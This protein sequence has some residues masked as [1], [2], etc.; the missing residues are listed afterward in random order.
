VTLH[1]GPDATN[2]AL[3]AFY[4]ILCMA[5]QGALAELTQR[6]RPRVLRKA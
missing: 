6:E 2:A 3:D 5:A 4:S 1:R